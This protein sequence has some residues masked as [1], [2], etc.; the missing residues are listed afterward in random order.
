MQVKVDF[1][2]YKPWS[3]AVSTYNDIVER[4]GIDKLESALEEI[5]CGEDPEDVKI[6]DLLWFEPETV[7]DALGISMDEEEEDDED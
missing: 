2:D 4:V 7:Y 6:N 5:F 1:Q 3:G